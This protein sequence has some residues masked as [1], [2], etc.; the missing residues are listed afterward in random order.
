MVVAG[1][2]MYYA[3][4]SLPASAA[5]FSSISTNGAARRCVRPGMIPFSSIL[6]KGSSAMPT[7]KNHR[8]ICKIVTSTFTELNALKINPDLTDLVFYLRKF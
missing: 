8:G 1:V 7:K 2:R 6:T 4:D 3:A 5:F